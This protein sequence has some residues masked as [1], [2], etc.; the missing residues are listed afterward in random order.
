MR[1][2][3]TKLVILWLAVLLVIAIIFIVANNWQG[4]IEGY[5]SV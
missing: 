5:H 1:K 4:F 3:Q 2:K